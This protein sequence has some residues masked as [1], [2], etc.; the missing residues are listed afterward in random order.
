MILIHYGKWGI[1]LDNLKSLISQRNNKLELYNL[2]EKISSQTFNLMKLVNT[3]MEKLS[4]EIGELN[5]QIWSIED[6]HEIN[7]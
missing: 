6:K 7:Q 1:N 5:M 4:A 3:E 2:Y